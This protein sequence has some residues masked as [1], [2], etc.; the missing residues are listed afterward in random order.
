MIACLSLE[1][2][3]KSNGSSKFGK[4]RLREHAIFASIFPS[5]PDAIPI[6]AALF[7]DSFV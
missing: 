3:S 6:R 5:E 4:G 1:P 2:L 7:F